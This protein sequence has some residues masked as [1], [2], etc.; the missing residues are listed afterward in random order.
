VPEFAFKVRMTP[1]QSQAVRALSSVRWVGL[2]H[3]AYKLSPRLTR[4]GERLYVVRLEAGGDEA[5]AATAI[6]SSGARV[7]AREGR[8]LVV[9]A[10][11]GRL[12]A[13]A[14]IQN[15]VDRGLRPAEA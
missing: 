2:Y 3:P 8:T 7:L 10:T 1:T 15:G 14:A 11:S 13:L 12:E 9:S 5:Q 6:G 4:A